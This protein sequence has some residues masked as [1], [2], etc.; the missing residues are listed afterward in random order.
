MKKIILA[1]LVYLLATPYSVSALTIQD[2]F[3]GLYTGNNT[4]WIT[5]SAPWDSRHM[6]AAYNLG[7]I[8]PSGKLNNEPLFDY[9]LGTPSSNKGESFAGVFGFYAPDKYTA[10]AGLEND[11]SLASKSTAVP[12]TATIW[13]FAAGILGLLGMRQK[14]RKKMQFRPFYNLFEHPSAFFPRPAPSS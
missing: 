11:L 14:I 2:H 1:C 5:A 9:R 7:A 4:V 6:N 13:P 3:T 12:F 8:N 10:P